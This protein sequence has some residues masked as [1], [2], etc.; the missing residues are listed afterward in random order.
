MK[1]KDS[2]ENE[3]EDFKVKIQKIIDLI[4][5]AEKIGNKDAKNFKKYT[6]WIKEK[7]SPY[8][9]NVN[10]REKILIIL[11]KLYKF[12]KDVVSPQINDEKLLTKLE[13]LYIN[14]DVKE[15]N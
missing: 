15:Y 11:E 13:V 12:N 3:K 2:S 14:S 9:T 7:S 4:K 10:I 6:K 1:N 8:S 5:K